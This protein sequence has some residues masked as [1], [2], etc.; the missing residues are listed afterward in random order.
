LE[1]RGVLAAS[2]RALSVEN[3]F[4][5]T[6]LPCG[7]G[8]NISL[9]NVPQYSEFTFSSRDSGLTIRVQAK[10]TKFYTLL[11]VAEHFH[12]SLHLLFPIFHC[13]IY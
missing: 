1:A 11:A 2:S 4:E 5:I 8:I 3:I 9:I 10:C 7:K 6:T 13:Y 12:R